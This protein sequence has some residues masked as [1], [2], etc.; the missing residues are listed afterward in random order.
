MIIAVPIE[1]E[2]IFQHFGHSELF[3]LYE[4]KE[5]KVLSAKDVSTNGNGHGALA[6][7]LQSLGANVLICGGIGGGA[8]TALGEKDIKIFG[9]V[10]GEANKAVE[11]YLSGS[12][13]YNPDV[14]CT[15]HH[16]EEGH[17]CGTH[18]C[19]K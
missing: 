12:L 9:G 19:G 15:H 5:G 6:G 14:A 10:T 13:S 17:S 7:M 2:M 3:R 4:V 8:K 18:S 16:E 11:A 1:N